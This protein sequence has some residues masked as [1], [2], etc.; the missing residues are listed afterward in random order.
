MSNKK[1][2]PLPN[3]ALRQ[4]LG[5]FG[6]F[7]TWAHSD[8]TLLQ[9]VETSLT[10]LHRKVDTLMATVKELSDKL[11]ETTTAISRIGAEEVQ[12]T[13]ELKRLRDLLAQGGTI[14]AAD[15]DPLLLKAQTIVDALK[16][17]DD[18]DIPNDPTN[19]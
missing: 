2:H 14:T 11:D 19:G 4:I 8:S 10:L 18:V 5:G 16:L 13:A 7:M 3:T 15:L 1:P 17:I 6:Q 9:Q 12:Q